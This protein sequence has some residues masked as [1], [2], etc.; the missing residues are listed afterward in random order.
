MNMNI[1]IIPTCSIAYIRQVGA[2]GEAN[3]ETMEQLKH[4]AKANNLMNSK[5]V[6][7]GIA[8]DNPRT[9]PPGDC[10]YDACILVADQHI[11]AGGNVQQGE[12][13]GGKYA[14]FTVAHTAEAIQKAWGEIFPAL[15]ESGCFPDT[16]RP[17]L[18]RYATELVEQH[19]CE[20]CVP[21]G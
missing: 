2:Y 21:I 19:L 18:E 11:P 15:S 13:I 14:V 16:A 1:E 6:I 7:L 12:I 5:S 17:V 3:M 9:T 8:H 4:W 10:R 20:I